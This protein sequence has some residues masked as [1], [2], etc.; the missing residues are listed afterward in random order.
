[1]MRKT[2]LAAIL[3]TVVLPLAAQTGPGPAAGASNQS[4]DRTGPTTDAGRQFLVVFSLGPGWVAGKPPAEQPSF[5]E[6]GQNLK[7]LRDAERIV[8]GARYADKGMIVL[9]ADSE[10]AARAELEADPG[11]KAG[12][13]TFELN[14][15]RVFYDGF[16]GRPQ[17]RP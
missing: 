7:R 12:I 2:G 10:A 13:F 16:L 8:L 9:R 1:M 6:H 4:P 15:L 3:L 14:E 11:V 17:G 5:R